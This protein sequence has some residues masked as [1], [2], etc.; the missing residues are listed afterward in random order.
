MATT[1]GSLA[2]LDSK[3]ARDAFIVR[4]L[5]AS[6]AIILGKTNLSEWATGR[7][8]RSSSGWRGGQTK[9][10]FALDRNPLRLEFRLRCR[11][12]GQPRPRRRGY[13]DRRA[14]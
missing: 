8:T 12:R 5:R 11:H 4:R 3:P 10:P 7:S 13:R 2:I 1:A 14:L 9:N 6:G